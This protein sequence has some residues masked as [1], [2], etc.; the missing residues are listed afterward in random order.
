MGLGMRKHWATNSKAEVLAVLEEHAIAHVHAGLF[1]CEGVFREKRLPREQVVSAFTQGWSFIDALPYWGP[2]DSTRAD[3]PYRSEACEF[4]FHSLRPYPFEPHTALLVADYAGDSRALSPRWQLQRQLEKAAT[5]GFEVVGASEFEFII[6]DETPATIADKQY[7]G[8]KTYAQHNR[9]WSGG[10]LASG[11][12]LLRDYDACMTAADIPL[13]HFCAELGPGCLEAALPLRGLL[14]AADD[15]ALF[16]QFTKAF[17][18]QRGL[19]ASFMAQLS[20]QHP[21]LGG[22]PIVSLRDRSTG[23]P[24]FHDERSPAGLS[25]TCLHFIAGVLSLMPELMALFATTVNAYRRYAPGNWAPRT[26]TWGI[27]NYTC[28]LRVVPG[29]LD[30]CRV[31][32]RLPGAD[33]NP[34]LGFAMLLGAGLHGIEHRLSPPPQTTQVGRELVHEDIG[35]L[36]RSLLEAA[37]RLK[38]SARARQFYGDVFVDHWVQRCIHEDIAM[39]RHVSAF[40]RMRYLHHV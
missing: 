9:C 10:F 22:H 32:F 38:G 5:M 31:E 6:L 40:E 13:D 2:N 37:E 17:F 8:L 14:T 36:P 1:D 7:D 28:G 4:D 11:A 39:R 26:A 20:D 25:S 15:A 27:G 30:A 21:G 16:K 33:L 3:L 12:E 29:P 19:M 18:I 23:Q 24:V 35:A 34:H